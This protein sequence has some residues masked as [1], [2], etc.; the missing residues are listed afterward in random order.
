MA[1]LAQA[2][3]ESRGIGFDGH[4]SCMDDKYVHQSF[5]S[6]TYVKEMAA[7]QVLIFKRRSSSKLH[8]NKS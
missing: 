4:K 7:Y 3:P 2:K 6:V 5:K 8:N 1:P